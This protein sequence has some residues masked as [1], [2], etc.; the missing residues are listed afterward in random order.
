MKKILCVLP[1]FWLLGGCGNTNDNHANA[2][3]ANH[4]TAN[5]DGQ[6]DKLTEVKVAFIASETGNEP[7]NFRDERG[8]LQ[9]FEYDVLQEIAKRSH[10]HFVY[11]YQPRQNLFE[12]LADNKFD[13]IV[14]SIA[15]T[16][17]RRKQ[18]AMSNPYLE[19]YPVTIISKDKDIKTLHQLKDKHVAIKDS[20]MDTLYDIVTQKKQEEELNDVQYMRSDWLAVQS[21]LSNKAEAAISDSSVIP[22]Y[23]EKYSEKKSPLYFAIDYDYPQELY[24]FV[25]NKSDSQLL[26]EVNAS[27]ADMKADGTYQSIYKKWF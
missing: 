11:S 27:L 4:E 7:L 25:L 8:D 3:H 17:D 9:G 19:V 2:N 6:Q 20:S 10:H 24:G 12:S 13:M 22:Y 5:T 1:L 14:G 23:V 21:V 18:Y 16:D 15:I 26:E